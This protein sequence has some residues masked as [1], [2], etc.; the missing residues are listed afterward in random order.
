MSWFVIHLIAW[1]VTLLLA[2]V[3]TRFFRAMA[4]RWELWDKPQSEHHKNHTRPTAVVGGL[5]MWSAWILAMAG[6]LAGAWLLRGILPEQLRE[7]IN[8]I[9][10]VGR[11]LAVIAGGGT[12]L[13]LMGLKDDK[14]AMP[15][16]RKFLVQ[17]LVAALT[18]ILGPRILVGYV[19]A[20]TS[21]IL[22]TLWLATIINA[23]NFFDNM[24]GLTGGVSFI[25][26]VFLFAIATIRGQY[27]VALLTAL[28][29]G[30]VLG[31]LFY[32]YPKATVFMGDC[33]SH[34]LGYLL[35]VCCILTTFYHHENTPNLLAVAIPL[36]VLAVPL[37][38]AMVVVIIRL[39]LH[40]PIYVGDNRHLSHRFVQIGLG[41]PLAVAAIWLLSFLAGAGALSLLWLPPLGALLILA[42]MLAMLALVLLIQLGAHPPAG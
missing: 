22:T 37:L 41:R 15:A 27:F 6:G 33:G 28:S 25:A 8:G 26:F 2:V 20:W 1:L 3:L 32:N 9:A 42:Q 14:K 5:A 11:T 38:D 35:G 18:A 40:K 39:R 31:F 21:W 23:M 30:A 19:P 12:I 10:T 7:E 17:F 34:F 24:D 16:S 29:S 4:P 13:S 36:M